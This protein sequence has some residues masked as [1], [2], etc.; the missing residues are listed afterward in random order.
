MLSKQMI[1]G[2]CNRGRQKGVSLICSEKRNGTNRKRSEESEE[3][4]T[5]SRKQGTQIGTNLRDGETTIKIQFAVL[6]GGTSGAERQIVQNAVSFFCGKR[7]DNKMLKVNI[8]LFIV[9]KFCCRLRRHL[10]SEENP[11]TRKS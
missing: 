11:E 1:S 5:N 6:R 10:K 9:E 2:T 8:L 7:H 3:I 4:G